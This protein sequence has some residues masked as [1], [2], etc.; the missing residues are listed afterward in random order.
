MAVI[1]IPLLSL[2]SHLTVRVNCADLDPKIADPVPESP[3][4]R[5]LYF[6]ITSPSKTPQ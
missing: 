6:P 4:A 2:T 5:G 3:S 1:K